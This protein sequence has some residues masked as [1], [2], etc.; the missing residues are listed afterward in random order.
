MITG[1]HTPPDPA[2]PGLIHPATEN[3]SVALCCQAYARAYR[4]AREAGKGHVAAQF[5]AASAYRN[6]MPP[7][8][9]PDN[10]R[11]FI[12]C[13]AHAMLIGALEASDGAKLLYAVQVASS[14]LPKP[15]A[16]DAKTAQ[17]PRKAASSAP[18]RLEERPSP[19][20]TQEAVA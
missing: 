17:I 6:A 4:E 20:P 13:A 15:A 16:K 2:N 1:L 11:S 18:G 8:D 14:L 7:L 3:P 10:I 19:V 12:A 9:G 5:I